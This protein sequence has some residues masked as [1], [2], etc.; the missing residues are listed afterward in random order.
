MKKVETIMQWEKLRE[1]ANQTMLCK[2]NTGNLK[3]ITD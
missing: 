1:E 2:R 3:I